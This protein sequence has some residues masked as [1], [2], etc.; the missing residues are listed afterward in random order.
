MPNAPRH[1]RKKL[2]KTIL[3]RND[4]V[5]KLPELYFVMDAGSS[6]EAEGSLWVKRS[7]GCA[8]GPAPTGPAPTT[9]IQLEPQFIEA[10]KTYQWELA[11][12]LVSSEQDRQDLA[13]SRARVAWM[14]KHISDGAVQRAKSL[15]I[16]EAEVERIDLQA[17]G[18][19]AHS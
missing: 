12:K 2:P 13:N 17:S 11:E 3:L 7:L 16:T 9:T 4:D 5:S 1:T 8:E 19:H 15:A 10:V 18:T 14:A 6:Q